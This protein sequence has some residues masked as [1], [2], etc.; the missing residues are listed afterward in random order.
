MHVFVNREDEI[1]RAILTL[2]D[3][4]NILVRGMTG[5]G[6]TA[7]IMAV[8]CQIEQQSQTLKRK[9][10]PIHIRQFVGG[11][12]EDFFRVVLYAL[13]K[14]LGPSNKR[15]REVIYALRQFIDFAENLVQQD[16][17]QRFTDHRGEV[18]YRLAP[19]VEKLAQSGAE[20]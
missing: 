11:T 19:G 6:K 16:V 3:G 5:I 8:R 10:L 20:L 18:L 9:V 13:A 7:F 14:Q 17:L 2:D 12:R 15:A 1:Q 4:E